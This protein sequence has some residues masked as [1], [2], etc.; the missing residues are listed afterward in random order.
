MYQ[1]A[2]IFVIILILYSVLEKYITLTGL[3]LFLEGV[4]D[5][6]RFLA[7]SP[8]LFPILLSGM[9][10]LSDE[11]STFFGVLRFPL[12]IIFFPSFAFF[13]LGSTGESSADSSNSIPLL[14][15]FRFCF[16]VFGVL[17][18]AVS[19]SFSCLTSFAGDSCLAFYSVFS[20]SIL[21]SS[22]FSSFISS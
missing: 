4:D 8:D 11:E 6:V 17:C 18:F 10:S 16:F 21:L 5:S 9:S 14:R 13:E 19:G 2:L 22:F 20:D 12:G 1:L 15:P 3:V 7:E